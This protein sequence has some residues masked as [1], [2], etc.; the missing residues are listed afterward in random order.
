[1]VGHLKRPTYIPRDTRKQTCRLT[2]LQTSLWLPLELSKF[3]MSYSVVAEM[4][5]YMH[6]MLGKSR[7]EFRRQGTY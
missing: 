5:Q 1:M 4:V 7:N 6:G 3:P 2:G